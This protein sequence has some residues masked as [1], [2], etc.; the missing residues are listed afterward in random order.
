MVV[1]ISSVSLAAFAQVSFGVKAGLNLSNFAG[2]EPS[3]GENV[4]QRAGFHF[5]VYVNIPLDQK[6]SVQPELLATTAGAT[7]D[8]ITELENQDLVKLEIIERLAYLSMPINLTYSFGKF[9][10]QAGPQVSIL[11]LSGDELTMT[12]V[13]GGSMVATAAGFSRDAQNL[14]EIDLGLNL[15]GGLSLGKFGLSGRYY[16]GMIDVSDD[17]TQIT[18]RVFQLSLTYRLVD[19]VD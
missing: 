11:L 13:S 16:M 4:E 10:L 8:E 12:R 19:R 17:S 2:D 14:K 6:L 1:V 15:G 9:N 5:G 18:N 7:W 3:N